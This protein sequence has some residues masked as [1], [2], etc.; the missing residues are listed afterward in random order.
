MLLLLLIGTS[1]GFFNVKTSPRWRPSWVPPIHETDCTFERIDSYHC[2]K[3]Y[4]DVN[5]KD[6]QITKQEIDEAIAEYLPMY[7]RP[8]L[9]W[10]GT[11]RVMIECD[12]DKNDVITSR[13]WE[14]SSKT[15]F[16]IKESQ[17]TVQWFCERIEK[18]ANKK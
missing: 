17:C 15:C 18:A 10:V 7:L 12:V 9:W 1:F 14:M 16:P 6:D 2:L 13:D 4:V 11:E 5:P 3:K 8:V